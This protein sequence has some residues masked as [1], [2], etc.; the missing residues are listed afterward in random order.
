MDS[1][2]KD[3]RYAIRNLIKR[4]AFTVVAVI[5]LALGIG[6]NTTIFSLANSVFLRPLPVVAPH[7][8]VWVFTD[9]ENPVSYPDYVDYRNQANLF[10]GMLAYDWVGLNLGGN[11]QAERV[12][13]AI[14]SANYFDVLGTKAELGR[15]FLPEE[16]N[17]PGGSPVA[18]IS[19]GLW[20]RNFNRDVNVIGSSARAQCHAARVAGRSC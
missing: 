12:Q 2:R 13:G 14:V 16:D 19:H 20:E 6:I 3:L 18:V 9:L 7:Q 10:D 8:L 11:G 5:T 4:P 17:T 1:I 15:T